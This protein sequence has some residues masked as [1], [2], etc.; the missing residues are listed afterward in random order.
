MKKTLIICG[1]Y[2]LPE[3]IG[4][5]MRTMNFVRFFRKIGTVDIAYHFTI[6]DEQKDDLIFSNKIFLKIDGNIKDLPNWPS[7]ALKVRRMPWPIIKFSEE[8]EKLLLSTIKDEDY[9]YILVRYVTNTNSLF[10][11]SEKFRMRTIIDFDDLFSDPLYKTLSDYHNKNLVG[12]VYLSLNW[13]F[14]KKYEN[15]CLNYGA[16]LLCSFDDKKKLDRKLKQRSVFVV[17][18]VYNNNSFKTYNFGDGFKNENVL[19][20]VGTLDYEPN[21][22]GLK[23]FIESIFPE[24]KERYHKSKLII[25]GRFPTDDVKEICKD[26]NGVELIGDVPDVREYYKACRVV[27]VPILAGG[28]TRIKILEAALAKRPILST[29]IGADGLGLEDVTDLLLFKNAKD[30]LFK[31]QILYDQNKYNSLIHNAKNVVINKCS[32]N[33]FNDTMINVLNEIEGRT[34]EEIL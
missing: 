34:N 25:V 32:I 31:Y 23:W 8:S 33:S 30:F 14:L 29:P 9:D 21:I 20:F 1:T 18:N 22:F 26:K 11:L 27:V 17:P 3:N 5:N 15:S 16:S 7:K 13:R 2:P 12:K 19:L 4:T 28:G 10:H 24:F 6:S